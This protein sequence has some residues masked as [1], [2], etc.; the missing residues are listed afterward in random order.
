MGFAK[1]QPILPRYRARAGFHPA[2]P[3]SRRR[4]FVAMVPA[5]AMPAF[6]GRADIT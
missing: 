1:A 4:F 5:P 3:F 6:G 2:L